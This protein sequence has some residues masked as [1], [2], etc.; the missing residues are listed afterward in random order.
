M[1]MNYVADEVLE[2]LKEKHTKVYRNRSPQNAES[3]YV[4]FRLESVINTYPSEDLYLHI[5]VYDKSERS[6][7]AIEDLADTIDNDLNLKVINDD[8]LNL[9][10][11]REQ[12]QYI[13]AEELVG[14]QAINLRYVVRAYF[15]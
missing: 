14:T 2:F 5:D 8:K 15:K 3:P 7:R 12:R 1:D 11:D 9:F 6:V 4:V 13:P 10:F